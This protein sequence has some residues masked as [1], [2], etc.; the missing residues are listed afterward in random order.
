[1]IKV[2]DDVEINSGGPRMKVTMVEKH[3][4]H[5]QVTCT[6][7]DGESG[8]SQVSTFPEPCLTHEVVR[9]GSE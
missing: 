1:M 3:P 7:L 9:G 4:D 2:G 5:P 8:T 6:W